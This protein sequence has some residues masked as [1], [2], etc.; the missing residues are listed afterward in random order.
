[1]VGVGEKKCD[2]VGRWRR[3]PAALF[4]LFYILLHSIE[5]AHGREADDRIRFI[6]ADDPG[7]TVILE[8]QLHNAPSKDY[9]GDEQKIASKEQPG[10]EYDEE[11][12]IKPYFLMPENGPRVVQ[13]Y[14]P[15]CGHCQ[16]FKTKYVALA[17]ETIVRLP[18]DQPEI[19]FHAVSCSVYHWIC[20]QHGVKGFPTIVAFKA[21]SV[22]PH[23][24]K[25][26][27]L[28]AESIAETVGVQL[29]APAAWG[30]TAESEVVEG[31][32]EFRPIDILGASLNGLVRTR[33]AVYKD[34]AL[35][36]MHALKTGVFSK[37]EDGQTSGP[38]DSVQREVFSDW[39]DLLYWALPPTWILHTLINDIRNN[40]DSVMVSEENL[41]FMIEKHQDVVNGGN[42]KWSTQCSKAYDQAGYSCGLWSLFHIISNGVIERH[43]AVLGA[44]DQVSTKFVAQTMR[45]YIDHFF[46]CD[47]CR[48]YFVEMFDTCGFD[49]CRR[50]KQPQKLPPPES[51]REFT[52]WLWE[53]HNDV[54]A[55]LFEA[56][57]KREGGAG[58]SKHKLNLASWPRAEECP[59]CRDRSGNWDKDAVLGHLKKEYWPGGVQNFRFVV[60]KKKDYSKDESSSFIS[61][62]LENFLFLAISAGIVMWC[63][64]KQYISFTGRH[65]KMDRDYV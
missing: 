21:N 17:K 22:E 55:R 61:D 64:R 25:E 37:E 62:L 47:Q 11:R 58:T 30:N 57:L 14:S 20:M 12:H 38:L 29:N 5:S 63:T 53:V 33:D 13:Y 18:D 3:R 28:T 40:I 7:A 32:D 35:S 36:F 46:D 65:K 2:S 54:N 51:W 16:F 8:Y 34:A 19:N 39:I 48:E 10:S 1:M 43:R 52:L 49:H 45:N 27:E 42:M 56:E 4:L 44:Q 31:D 9:S 24:L 60:L 6:Y 23:L 59:T 41:L 26:K 15:W 50:F